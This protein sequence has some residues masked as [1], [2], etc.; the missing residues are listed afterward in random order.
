M[1]E[2]ER[3][4]FCHAVDELMYDLANTLHTVVGEL[5]L[6]LYGE[7]TGQERQRIDGSGTDMEKVTNLVEILK[8][9]SANTHQ[10]CLKALEEL[11]HEE[12][13]DKLREKMKKIR[14]SKTTSRKFTTGYFSS[15][16]SSRENNW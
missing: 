12:I 14:M 8:T 10:K 11:K 6:K 3:E 5:K 4:K 9:K 16:T 15:L 1:D 7:F 13:A 2:E